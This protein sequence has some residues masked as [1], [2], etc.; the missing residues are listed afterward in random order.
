MVALAAAAAA[1]FEVGADLVV[2]RRLRTSWKPS[3]WVG[4]SVSVAVVILPAEVLVFR[5]VFI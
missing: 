1:F 4:F 3:S 2:Q 5:R